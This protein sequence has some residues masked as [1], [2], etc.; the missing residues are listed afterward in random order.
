MVFNKVLGM[1]ERYDETNIFVR[2]AIRSVVFKENKL[3]MIYSNRGDFKFPGGGVERN[4]DHSKTI[5]REVLEESGY[6]IDYIGEKIGIV[7]ERRVDK[8]NSSMQ[9]EMTSHYYICNISVGQQEQQLDDYE[10]ELDFKPIWISI[11]DAIL[12]NKKIFNS[13]RRDINVWVEREL[14]VLNKLKSYYESMK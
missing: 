10:K 6:N 4:E 12:C 7:T 8:F 1:Q 11:K 3:L 9:F 5:I 2:E 14:F 13:H